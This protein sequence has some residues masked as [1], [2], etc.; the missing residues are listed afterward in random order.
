MKTTISRKWLKM[1][2]IYK[3]FAKEWEAECDF[4]DT[5]AMEMYLYE[6]RGEGHPSYRNGFFTGKHWMDATIQMWRE[7]LGLTLFK[8][9]LYED[10]PHWWLDGLE[11][12]TKTSNEFRNVGK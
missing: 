9:E 10:F 11:L 1:A 4:S 5:A 7:D 12:I 8:S 3:I 2:E 6:S